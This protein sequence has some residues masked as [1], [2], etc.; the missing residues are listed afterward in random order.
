MHDIVA[1]VTKPRNLHR[2]PSSG[3]GGGA[4]AGVSA[5]A[6]V[7]ASERLFFPGLASLKSA[8]GA[9][10]AAAVARMN[11]LLTA[12]NAPLSAASSYPGHAAGMGMG[13]GVGGSGGTTGSGS[14][15]SGSLA[16]RLNARLSGS[17]LVA[18]LKVRSTLFLANIGDSRCVLVRR[19]DPPV[20]VD[21]PAGAVGEAAAAGAGAG[22]EAGT[23]SQ[24]H[25]SASQDSRDTV[26]L[27]AGGGSSQ[28][29]L[30]ALTTPA[31]QGR[32]MTDGEEADSGDDDDDVA[33]AFNAAA[34]SR[35]IVD[36]IIC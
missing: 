29:A 25:A 8:P 22:T 32:R 34:C 19:T 33:S 5:V 2:A 6:S 30:S 9:A 16:L 36:H 31:R 13:V 28:Q 10:L 20:Y 24:L 4:G 21:E 17:T 35:S 7:N 27:S 14:G 15:G 23:N 26:R 1:A 11:A 18:A 12:V 3:S